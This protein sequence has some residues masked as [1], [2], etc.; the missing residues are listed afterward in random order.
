[1][2]EFPRVNLYHCFLV[3]AIGCFA[4]LF[5]LEQ[6]YN[7]DIWWHLKS[8]EWILREGAVPHYDTFSFST[9]GAK[10]MNS[11]WLSGPVF[12]L[13]NQL[14][15]IDLLILVKAILIGSA[16]AAASL[17]LIRSGVNPYLALL[18]IGWAVVVARFRFLLRPQLFMFPALVMLFWFLSRSATRNQ[19]LAFLVVPLTILWVNLHGSAF[20]APV[21]GLFLVLEVLSQ[22]IVPSDKIERTETS[23]PFAVTL[24]LSL[25]VAT[26]LSPYGLEMFRA[27]V[28]RA[29]V[30]DLVANNLS[31]EEHMPLKWGDRSG[32]WALLIATAASFIPLFGRVRLFHLFAFLGTVILSINSVRYVGLAAVIQAMILGLNLQQIVDRTFLK[33]FFESRVY[34]VAGFIVLVAV[35]CFAFQSTFTPEKIYQWG[36]GVNESRYPVAEVDY[37][38]H[39]QFEGNLYNSWEPGGYILWHLPQ[40]HTLIDGRVL[41]EQLILKAKLDKMALSAFSNYLMENDVKGA[42]LSKRDTLNVQR[43]DGLPQ[44][45]LKSFSEKFLVYVRNDFTFPVGT[46]QVVRF[47]YIRPQSYDFSYL[48][49]LAQG[50]NSAEVEMEFKRGVEMSPD[51]FTLLFQYGLFLEGMK[52]REALDLYLKAAKINPALGFSHFELGLRAG[53]LALTYKKWDQAISILQQA[54]DHGNGK[55]EHYFLLGT[56]YYQKKGLPEAEKAYLNVVKLNPNHLTTLK[57]LGFLYVDMGR[58]D[59]AE[60]YFEKALTLDSGSE[61]AKYGYA[62]ALEKQIRP[63]ATQAWQQFLQTFPNSRWAGTAR[64]YLQK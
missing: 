18:L 6:V 1:M 19:R 44:F 30:A 23:F 43:F 34:K 39:I 38:K 46:E 17:F 56:A 5:A 60:S 64:N 2:S 41:P 42:L 63:E 21:F 9:S 13:L 37:L 7:Y 14:G 35:G 57:N 62:L 45:Q 53:R 24:F 4:A 27:V 28:E 33:D 20:I 26:L 51:N 61:S 58:F 29:V 59:E 3:F 47:K 32:Y 40:V 15:G 16:F 22:K 31:V 48:A 55:A 8:G 50:P 54:L 52:R 25:F 12:V 11:S 36:L 49:P 10:W